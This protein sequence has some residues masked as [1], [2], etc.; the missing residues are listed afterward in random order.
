M[1]PVVLGKVPQNPGDGFHPVFPVGIAETILDTRRF[2]FLM[3]CMVDTLCVLNLLLSILLVSGNV[4]QSYGFGKEG[5]QM[6]Y[7]PNR[8]IPLSTK[9]EQSVLKNTGWCAGKLKVQLPQLPSVGQCRE[10]GRW[11]LIISQALFFFWL[12]A[13]V[14]L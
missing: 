7:I 11:Y 13:W 9:D 14:T 4:P 2:W 5:R 8:I 6:R 3:V 1:R 10:G 12:R